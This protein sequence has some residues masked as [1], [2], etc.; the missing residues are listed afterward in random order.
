MTPHEDSEQHN[1]VEPLLVIAGDTGQ[2][3]EVIPKTSV[4]PTTAVTTESGNSSITQLGP[5][6][7]RVLVPVTVH[8]N[9]DTHYC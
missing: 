3:S 6:P 7:H 8:R 1:Y 9:M 4:Q 2:D 5:S